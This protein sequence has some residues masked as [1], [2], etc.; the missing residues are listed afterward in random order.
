[1]DMAIRQDCRAVIIANRTPQGL[2]VIDIEIYNNDRELVARP[3]KNL[4]DRLN[5]MP[6]LDEDRLKKA[7]ARQY[8][9][10]TKNIQFN[11]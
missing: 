1:M 8:G 3:T 7:V 2:S 5:A 4:I 9:I 10:P 6:F 11:R